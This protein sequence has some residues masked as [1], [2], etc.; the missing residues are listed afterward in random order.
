MHKQKLFTGGI[1]QMNKGKQVFGRG[2][3]I[4]TLIALAGIHLWLSGSLN[5]FINEK[6][7]AKTTATITHI[8]KRRR[9]GRIPHYRL[10]VKYYVGG[11][12]YYG[13]VTL[14]DPGLEIGSTVTVIYNPNNPNRIRTP[15]QNI[16]L[17][18]FLL[19][20]ALTGIPMYIVFMRRRAKPKKELL[21][22]DGKTMAG[23]PSSW[24][25]HTQ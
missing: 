22:G 17:W 25:T 14:A 23:E 3:I 15:S 10:S 2:F 5:D 19:T 11:Q 9:L 20:V 6:F 18:M 12:E 7:A 24:P 16:G 13:M 8:S 1:L 21:A 4:Y